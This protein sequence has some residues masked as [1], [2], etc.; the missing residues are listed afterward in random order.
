[1]PDTDLDFVEAARA[2]ASS[3][4]ATSLDLPD[5]ARRAAPYGGRGSYPF[6]LPPEHRWLNLLEPAR[7]IARTRFDAAGIRWHGDEDG[8]NPHL[9]SS[10]IQC[11]NALAPWVDDPAALGKIFN[12]VL[13]IAEV[14]SFGA[15][16][17]S[18]YDLND[19]VVFEWQGGHDYLGE[20]SSKVVRGAHATSADAAIR[21]RAH[22]G[23]V[24]IALIEWKYLERYPH[25]GRLSGTAKYHDGRLR[26]Y[27]STIGGPD[28]P[29]RFDLGFDYEDLFAE[30]IYQ[31]A[32]TQALAAA[33][34][35]T[36]EQDA[37]RVVVVYATPE[38]NEP[39]R[40]SLGSPR[41]ERYAHRHGLDL[42]DAWLHA[43]RQPDRFVP[44]PTGRLLADDLDMPAGFAERYAP[45]GAGTRRRATLERR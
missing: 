33:M 20:W 7:E 27:A 12:G 43:L 6:V 24:E 25:H 28:G 15:S 5:D 11:L 41:F 4:K 42:A 45:L 32:R 17:P 39:L 31:L 30:P 23:H 44:F 36:R 26:R 9:C 1:M 2:A 40:S 21:Y 22:G 16:T 37:Q 13:P 29:V 3:W 14:L 18:G 38:A 10:Q 34:E 19:H 35:Q 8:P